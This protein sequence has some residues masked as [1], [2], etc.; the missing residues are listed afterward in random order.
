MSEGLPLEELRSEHE[1]ALDVM[2]QVAEEARAITA[3]APSEWGL[4]ADRLLWRLRELRRALLLHFRKEEDGLFPDVRAQ[5]AEG[6]PP[7]DILSQFFSDQA[8]D[9]L[10]AHQLL[11]QRAQSLLRQLQE[12]Q[13][14]GRLDVA[15][16]K[17]LPALA[18]SALD[19]LRRHAQKEDR[20]IFPMVERLLDDNQIA[21]VRE[22]MRAISLALEK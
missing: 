16:C 20:L 6:A 7:K 3:G 2:R 12:L 11:R 9:D 15:S 8:D 5:V 19:L 1:V 4:E 18:D 10:K 21:A 22:R 17:P 13:R 14:T